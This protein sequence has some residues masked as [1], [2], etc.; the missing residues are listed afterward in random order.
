MSTKI[1][2]LV[3]E[4]GLPVRILLTAGQSHDLNAAPG[5]SD[6]LQSTGAASE[7]LQPAA[8]TPNLFCLPRGNSSPRAGEL[9]AEKKFESL[10]TEVRKDF[11]FVL[12][13]GSPVLAAADSCTGAPKVD[14]TLF[15]LRAAST[16]R[17]LAQQAIALLEENGASLLGTILNRMDVSVGEYPFYRYQGYGLPQTSPVKALPRSAAG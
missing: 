15:V 2:A 10:L 3:D 5:L 14:G 6:C 9:F 11:D 16:P 8:A 12:I 17:P 1:N 7:F 4:N 13:D